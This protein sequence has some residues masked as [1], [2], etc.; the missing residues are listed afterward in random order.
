M[1]E[2]LPEV[3]KNMVHWGVPFLLLATLHYIRGIADSLA[4]IKESVAVVVAEIGSLKEA[5]T[6]HA[7]ELADLSKRIGK[8]EKN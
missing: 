1:N 4:K 3:Y 2:E 8:F 7:K 6:E 5:K